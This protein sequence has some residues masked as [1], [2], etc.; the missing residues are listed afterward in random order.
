MK[1]KSKHL[2]ISFLFALLCF[3]S[4][5]EEITEINIP[6][7]QE[8]IVPNST[9]VSLMSRTTANFGAADNILDN[10]SCFSVELPVTI[11]ITDITLIIETLSDLEQLESLLRDAS[12]DANL[13]FI[14][15]ITIIFNDYSQVVIENEDELESFINECVANETD[16]INCVD[17]VYPI[18]FSVFNSEFNLI[19]TVIIE[20]DETLYGFLNGLEDDDNAVIVSLNFPVTLNY[21]NGETIEVNTNQ[22]LAEA[23]EAAGNDCDASNCIEESLESN[24]I[25]C[26][27]E[28]T[29]YSSFPE[30]TGID[31]VFYSNGTFDIYQDG[32]TFNVVSNWSIISTAGETYLFLETDFEDLGGDWKI[33]ECDDA[34][35]RFT[36]GEQTMVINKVCEDDLNCSL[37]D[38]SAILQECPWDFSNGTGNFEND[39]MIFNS[40][41]DLQISE[42]LAA[43]AIGGGWNLSLAGNQVIITFS[44]LT[45]FQDTLEGDWTIVECDTGRIVLQKENETLVLEQNCN[46]GLFSCF[47]D[48]EIVTCEGPNNVPVYNLSANTIGLV[49]C[50]ENFMPSFH[51]T[52]SDAQTNTNAIVNTEAY[53]TLTA[54]VYL[55][56]EADNGDF[57]IFNVYLNTENCN[58][59]ECFQSFNAQLEICDNGYDGPYQFN[60]TTAFA[61]CTPS[62]D[63]VT[64]YEIQADAEAGINQIITPEVYTNLVVEQIIYVR[65]E[66]N[67]Q[68]EIFTIQLSIIDCNETCSESD[69]SSLLI[70]CTWN[71]VNYNGSDNLIAYNFDFETSN[72]IVVI[73]TDALVIDATWSTS[74]SNEGVI[75]NFSNVAGPNIQAINGSWLIV[76]CTENQLVLHNV[77]DSSIEIVLNRTCE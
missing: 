54:Q 27:W 63:A 37:T 42:G 38:I 1:T 46:G 41:G 53:E 51:A 74:Q 62:A 21:T 49:V 61:N 65:A 28:I 26:Q 75:I 22:E 11:V 58:L 8:A 7:D 39:T 20:N 68:F 77:N 76:E 67:N 56:I 14:F 18:S 12:N 9:L 23:I 30:F 60:L 31:F 29:T 43:S 71:V 33:I 45:A 55:R 32:G 73:Y 69:V 25:E 47:G 15:P 17:F 13:D 48:F 44:E 59:F 64:Y 50:T 36:K 16:V 4:C 57:E 40:N 10:V 19:D 70:D 35:I 6:N 2:F 66:I 34:T 72:Q 52:F 3:T 24:L 5:Q